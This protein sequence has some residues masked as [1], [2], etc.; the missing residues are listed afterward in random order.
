MPEAPKIIKEIRRAVEARPPPEAIQLDGVDLAEWDLTDDWVELYIS[1]NCFQK[2][3]NH[4]NAYRDEAMEVMGLLLGDVFQ[5]RNRIY[6]VAEDTVAADVE[7]S[8]ATS[9]RFG[10]RGLDE[11]ARA[12]DEMEYEYLIVGWYHSHP[13]FTTFLSD[14]DLETQKKNF[15]KPF[16]ATI[17]IDPVN[18]QFRSYKVIDDQYIEK[19]FLL[20]EE[21]ALERELSDRRRLEIM[22]YLA[23]LVRKGPAGGER[24]AA[25]AVPNPKAADTSH[26]LS[27]E[28]RQA[29]QTDIQRMIDE[30][31]RQLERRKK[32]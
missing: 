27:M 19:R 14:K 15:S 25:P 30:R 1:H 2:M 7:D 4:C 17:V 12:L 18:R 24:Q 32:D 26:R 3:V 10:N 5:W 28:V 6:T 22:A 8:T 21:S 11:V 31:N 13:G 9:V 29:I 23:S 16:H 20:Y